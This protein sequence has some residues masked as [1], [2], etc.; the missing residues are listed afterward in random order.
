MIKYLLTG[1]NGFLG[2]VIKDTIESPDRIVESLGRSKTN[3]MSIDLSKVIPIFETSYDIV[4]HCAGKAHSKPR[5]VF[6]KQEFFEV[7]FQATINLCL[8]L[9]NLK[10]LPMQFVFI[11]SV[12]VYGVDSGLDID[13]RQPLRGDTPYALSK[14]KAEEYLIN[15]GQKYGIEIL[16]LR[17][18]LI[19]GANAPGNLGKMVNGIG[20]GR[21]LSI[22]GGKARKSMVLADDVAQL[23]NTCPKVAGVYN[24]TDGVHPSFGELES[25]ISKQLNKSKPI[26]I[27][28][29][30]AKLLG[31]V[32]DVIP[33]F[34]I[35]TTTVNKIVKD[36]T[37]SDLKA[38]Q[39]L[40]WNPTSVIEN[41]K[42]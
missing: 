34:L 42:I 23:I 20:K 17:L 24:L 33:F 36:L 9:E 30:L 5:T 29:G 3:S 41:W 22:G 8:A 32:G 26:I 31:R 4:I 40:G 6:E 10:K 18:P 39:Q 16:I 28:I 1:A 21:Y 37:F 2:S 38:R 12:A 19:I 13:E 11:S 35:N 15:W 25:L 27:P 14:I 7:N